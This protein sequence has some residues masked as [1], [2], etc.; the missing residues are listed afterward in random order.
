MPWGGGV[1][2]AHSSGLP[3]PGSRER[4]ELAIAYLDLGDADTARGLLQEVATGTDPAAREQAL[5]LLGRLG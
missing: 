1:D 2:N 3:Q 5:E 4:L